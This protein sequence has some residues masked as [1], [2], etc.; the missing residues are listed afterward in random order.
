MIELHPQLAKDCI[1][2]CEF[3][4]CSLLLLDDAN[5]PWFI[6]V[7]NRENITELHHLGRDDQQQ[8]LSESMFFSRC[9]EDIW[10]PDKINIAALGNVVPQLHVHHIARFRDD[11]SWPAPVWGAVAAVPYQPAQV[12]QIRDSLRHW[13]SENCEISVHWAASST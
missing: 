3:S 2:L 6:L 4:L 9:L 5:Y 7:P 10:S 1:V 8:L 13:F 11:A 12:E